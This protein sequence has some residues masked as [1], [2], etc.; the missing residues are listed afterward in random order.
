VSDVITSSLL[1]L[2]LMVSDTGS[3][4]SLDKT[5]S[6]KSTHIFFTLSGRIGVIVDIKNKARGENVAD[7]LTKLQTQMVQTPEVSGAVGNV[8]HAR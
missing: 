5:S 2:C 3:L 7:N 8:S 6:L 1:S 4:V